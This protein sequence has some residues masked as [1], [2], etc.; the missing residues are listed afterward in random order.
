M[1]KLLLCA[2]LLTGCATSGV[3]RKDENQ[4]IKEFYAVIVS[5]TPVTLSSN[6]K[7]SMAVGAGVG[8]IDQLDG[9]HENMIAGAIVGAIISGVFTSIVE[10]DDNAFQYQLHST[11]QGTF[12]VIQKQMIPESVSC[13]KVRSSKAVALIEASAEHCAKLPS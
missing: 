12:T 10:G 5:V 4:I 7:T 9:N 1:K 6:V 13:V 8:A 11:T 2:L 3:D